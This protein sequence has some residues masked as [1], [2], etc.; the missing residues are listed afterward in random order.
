ETLAFASLLTEGVPIRLTGQD[1]QRGTFSHRHQV[2]VD[3]DTGELYTPLAR[4]KGSRA[5]FEIHNSPLSEMAV[6]G[7]EYGYSVGDPE[8]LVLWEAQFGDFANGAQV[9]IDQFIAGAEVKWQQTSGLV[10]LLPH[11]YEGQGPEH[12]SARLERFLQLAAQ[13][14]LR[15]AN[16]TTSAQYFHLLRRQAL[17]LGRDARPLIVMS[18][19]SLLRH[20]I[21]AS[22]LED[23]A[24]GE[25]R[26]VIGDPEAE[27][28]REEIT[29][30][31]LC[32]GKVYADLMA[33]EER[34]DAIAVALARVEELYPFPKEELR[35]QLE[36]YPNLEEVV[37]VQEE[38]KNM[39]AWSFIHPRLL[40]LVQ[41]TL[42]V[43]YEGR[44]HRASPAEG[45]A[46]KHAAEQVRIVR[47]AWEGAPQRRQARQVKRA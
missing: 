30:L 35:A 1:V 40:D 22:H 37:W 5:S 36:L 10:M 20:P 25:F 45:Y 42:T 13:G 12:S 47:A 27:A 33:G 21:A 28:R 6:V 14:N 41:G 16:C 39:G 19:K 7:F 26:P 24:T 15:V 23:L 18:P 32:S 34:K 29:R 4:L 38:P 43:R 3:A 8:V 31:L 44:P 46:D 9:I 2:L 11:G 17:S